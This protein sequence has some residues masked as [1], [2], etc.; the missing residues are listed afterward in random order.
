MTRNALIL[1]GVVLLLLG[2]AGLAVPV[3][4]TQQ[5]KDVA[6]IGDLKLQAKEDTTHFIPP[7]LSGGILAAGVILVGAGFYRG[8]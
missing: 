6:K 8:R 7:L 3:F 2:I 1:V 4:T 5:T